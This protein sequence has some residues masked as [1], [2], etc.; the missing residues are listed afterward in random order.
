MGS[1]H[2]MHRHMCRK[3]TPPTHTHINKIQIKS[4]AKVMWSG[5]PSHFSLLPWVSSIDL[6]LRNVL[7][8]QDQMLQKFW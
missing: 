6:D 2:M 4:R 8:N 7:C 5:V 3:N 1:T